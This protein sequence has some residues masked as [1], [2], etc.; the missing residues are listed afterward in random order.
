M[1]F[2]S[3]TCQDHKIT[4]NPVKLNKNYFEIAKSVLKKVVYGHATMPQRVKPL[5]A[6]CRRIVRRKWKN[7]KR[8]DKITPLYEVFPVTYTRSCVL[9]FI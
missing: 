4:K 7:F 6:E 3:V 5:F 8:F 2:D 9:N 1:N